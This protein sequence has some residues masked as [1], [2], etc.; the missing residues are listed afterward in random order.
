[1]APAGHW[2]ESALNTM[3]VVG[4]TGVIGEAT[5]SHFAKLQGWN[6]VA[7]SRRAPTVDGPGVRHLALDLTDRDACQAA[8]QALSGVTHVVYTAVAEQPGLVK[9]WKD[10]EQMQTNL[11]MLSNLFQALANA[12]A[13]THVTLLQGGKAYGGHVGHP[14]PLPAT[15]RAPRDAHENFYW[16]QEDFIRD[17]ARRIGF[18]WTIFRPAIVVG[19]AWGAAMNPLLP[20][21]T[22]AALRREE[23]KP[24]SFPG[25]ATQVSEIVG[26][27]LLAEAFAWAALSPAARNETF[28]IANGDVFDW[29]EAWPA[30][31]D[32]LGVHPGPDAPLRL[33]EY[34][35]ARTDLWDQIV[36]RESLRPIG[37][38][39]FLGESHHYADLILRRGVE[40]ILRPTL[41]STIKLRQ[42]G[43]GA[44]RDSE[45]SIRRWIGEMQARRLIPP[46]MT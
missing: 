8:G 35:S 23:G 13:L 25:G 10:A 20:L 26:A 33:V 43:F 9:G 46:R 27:D 34:L 31:A 14:P 36:E 45:D 6:A 24:F 22:Y 3:L 18:A 29:R 2:E 12:K 32:V 28:N 41:L 15:E 37:L 11:Q 21:A 39:P 1:L 19:A 4:A 16:L 44:C 38:L 42:A 40:T 30:L 5:L 7:V 17:A